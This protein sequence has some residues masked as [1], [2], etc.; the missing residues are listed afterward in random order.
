MR[1]ILTKSVQKLG[2]A[3]EVKEVADGY[4]RNF[5]IP[6]GFAALATPKKLQELFAEDG[7][8]A[9]Q[10]ARKEERAK[11][12]EQTLVGMTLSL[13]LSANE[14]GTLYGAV[15][16]RQIAE[17]LRAR[18]Y[19]VSVDQIEL[20][21]EPIKRIGTYSITLNC[22]HGAMSEVQIDVIKSKSKS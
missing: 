17:A 1:V 18:G 2:R 22:G 13:T 9:A 7:R 3:G 12:L 20:P 15:G 5:L 11:K 10:E 14:E 16:A 8:R 4:A 19:M 6:R 21:K